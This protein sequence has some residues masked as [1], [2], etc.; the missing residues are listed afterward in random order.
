[1]ISEKMEAALNEQINAEFE[2]AYL[3]LSMAA[4]FEGKNLEGMANWMTIQFKEE[5][6]HALKFYNYVVE[7]GGRVV[8]KAIKAP[9][10]EWKDVME[11]FTDTLKHENLVSSLINNLADLAISEKDHATNNML[12]WF[13]AEQVEEE[14]NA[15]RIINQLKM[16]GDHPQGIFM[17]DRE[18]A[19]R[20]FVDATQAAK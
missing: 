3:Y 8:L 20:V 17:L 16:I 14:A 18:L 13:I 4:W 9:R 1:M 19:T 10:T 11:V 6:T 12:Q 7:R 15:E 5:Q 2:S